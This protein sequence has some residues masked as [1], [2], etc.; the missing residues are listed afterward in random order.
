MSASEGTARAGV[1]CT[2]Q[3]PQNTADMGPPEAALQ[4]GPLSA[5]KRR[6]GASAADDE[7]PTAA[8]MA[9]ER[10]WDGD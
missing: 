9:A 7:P 1:A 5:G 8:S 3:P 4:L 2:P 6:G 10:S